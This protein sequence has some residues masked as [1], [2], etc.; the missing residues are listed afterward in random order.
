MQITNREQFHRHAINARLSARR[1]QDEKARHSTGFVAATLIERWFLLAGVAG[2]ARPSRVM[3]GGFAHPIAT[4]RAAKG[5]LVE[6]AELALGKIR[7]APCRYADVF[8]QPLVQAAQA[9]SPCIPAP[10]TQ[11]PAD[12]P[13]QTHGWHGRHVD[14]RH[15]LF[16]AVSEIHC[17]ALSMILSCHGRTSSV[18]FVPDIK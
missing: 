17:V 13:V 2:W 10:G 14:P 15:F 18:I 7:A 9:L 12:R 16:A 3:L 6:G 4:L 5:L 11:P 1:A 8:Q